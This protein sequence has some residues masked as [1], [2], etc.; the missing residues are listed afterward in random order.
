VENEVSGYYMS[1]SR[2]KTY[3]GIW[4]AIPDE[5]WVVCRHLTSA[6]LAQLLKELAEN[7]D[8]SKY[9]K[10]RRGPKKTAPKRTTLSEGHHVSTARLLAK[11]TRKP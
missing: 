3:T 9:P 6:K 4:I 11:R 1:L 5:K 2:A 10:H 7:V 8:L